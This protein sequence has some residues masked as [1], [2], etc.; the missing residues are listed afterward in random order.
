MK[1]CWV[2]LACFLGLISVANGQAGIGLRGGSVLSQV[3]YSFSDVTNPV[4][5]AQTLVQGME[6]GIIGRY[7]NSKNLG[8]QAEINYSRQ[9]WHIYLQTEAEQMKE[10]E[11]IQVPLLSYLQ[12]GRGKLKFT[13]QAGAF[14]AYVLNSRDILL[15]V[16]Q[17][18][19][20]FVRIS[21]QQEEPWQYGVLVGGGPSF[22]FPFGVVQ[23]EGRFSH[24]LS[25]LVRTDYK[26]N[27]GFADFEA[28]HLQSITFGLQWV[29]MF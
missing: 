20:G 16:Q 25:N 15:P 29:Y 5:P 17:D 9:G 12:L 22:T 19:E 7:M 8:M 21:H 14:A 3:I 26:A 18:L 28:F 27:A 6:A 10:L 1:Q 13:V 23:L 24:A 11:I 4:R 2:F